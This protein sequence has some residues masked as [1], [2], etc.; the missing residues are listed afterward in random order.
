MDPNFSIKDYMK[1]K[2]FKLS[3]SFTVSVFDREPEWEKPSNLESLFT[4]EDI[5]VYDIAESTEPGYLDRE[6]KFKNCSGFTPPTYR[7]KEELINFCNTTR[8]IYV[9]NGES[10]APE[11][12]RFQFHET[13]YIYAGKFIK[14]CLKKNFF[15]KSMDLVNKGGSPADYNP[16]RYI[17]RIVISVWDNNLTRVVLK[18]IFESCRLVDYD[19]DWKLDYTSSQAMRPSATFS[20]L[21]YGIDVDPEN[22]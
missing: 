21:Q 7:P 3:D 4:K 1:S 15:D 19:Y 13:E 9:P 18:H 8:V 11:P 12:L 10:S 2:S 17:D 22:D 6:F 16:Y 14:Y 5:K 20:Y